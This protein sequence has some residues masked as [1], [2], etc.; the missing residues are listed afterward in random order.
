MSEA[1]QIGHWPGQSTPVCDHHAEMM[2]R[3]ANAMGFSV[4]FTE[5]GEETIC[6][7]C[8]NEEKRALEKL[9]EK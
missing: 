6:K 8:E 9:Y 4:S 1:T 5:C 7:N 3:I 2:Q